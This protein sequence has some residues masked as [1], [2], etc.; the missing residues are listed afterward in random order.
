MSIQS[1]YEALFTLHLMRSVDPKRLEE[2][3]QMENVLDMIKT[4]RIFDF[5][6]NIF[7]EIFDDVGVDYYIMPDSKLVEA[8]DELEYKPDL[9]FD[10]I[11]VSIPDL[12]K[13]LALDD[14]MHKESNRTDI[15]PH[16]VAGF[17]VTRTQCLF[18]VVRKTREGSYYRYS[19][20]P[21][22]IIARGAFFPFN[23]IG[24]DIHPKFGVMYYVTAMHVLE[25]IV[26]C[27]LDM[28]G[29]APKKAADKLF[30][31]TKSKIPNPYYSIRLKE[32]TEKIG[33]KGTKAS[34]SYRFD[35]ASHNVVRIMRG[36][37]PL[38]ENLEKNLRK[39]EDRH[40]IKTEAD[41][42]PQVRQEL[43][44]RGIVYCEGEW[45]TVLIVRRE[46]PNGKGPSDAPY[47]PA[48]RVID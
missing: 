38:D 41:I 31:R 47:V 11:F 26:E 8:M 43:T 15:D 48:I 27:R 33:I 42:T 37:L 44:R 30:K 25:R 20:D 40:I 39:R 21:T 1:R 4:A 32:I 3:I 24:V 13:R 17:F 9:P 46:Y 7:E 29:I 5:D 16:A 12:E 2:R 6:S 14:A 35:V 22:P 45:M 34:P 36:Q 10:S 28:S 23:S 19:Y 18:V